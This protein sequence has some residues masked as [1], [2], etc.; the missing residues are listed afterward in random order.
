MPTRA[1]RTIAREPNHRYRRPHQ[2]IT[3]M[4][5]D[6]APAN[7]SGDVNVNMMN[8]MWGIRPPSAAV[9]GLPV[10]NRLHS[11]WTAGTR[12]A[13]NSPADISE[14]ITIAIIMN[15]RLI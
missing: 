4:P 8:T 13:Y 11:S 10:N 9:L 6:S 2:R 7:N 1:N 5:V 15:P 14:K 12:D 3:A